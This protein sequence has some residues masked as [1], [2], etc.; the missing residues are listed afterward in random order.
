MVLSCTNREDFLQ[1]TVSL[2]RYFEDVF[3]R[4]QNPSSKH[5]GIQLPT[6]VCGITLT[7]TRRN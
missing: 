5:K 4:L 3:F 1:V 7:E 2:Q 6:V